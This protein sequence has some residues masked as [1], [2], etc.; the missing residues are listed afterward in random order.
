M[1]LAAGAASGCISLT[2]MIAEPRSEQVL[3]PALTARMLHEAGITRHAVTTPDG[4]RISYLE[5]PAADRG[6]DFAF[7]RSIDGHEVTSSFESHNAHA[8]RALPT[9]GTVLLLHGWS[10]DATS[11]VTWGEALAGHGYRGIAIDLRNF[12]DSARAPAGFGPREAGDV[13]AVL[14]TLQAR[15]E[16]PA[17]VFLFGVSYGA[18]TALF[19]EPALRGRIAGIIA[20]DPFGNAADAIRGMARNERTAPAHGFARLAR[21]WARWRYD[22]DAVEQAIAQADARLQLD[23]AAIDTSPVLAASRTCTVLLHGARDRM[24][25]VAAAR[26][27]AG[28]APRAH[29]TELPDEDHL[30][31]PVRIDWLAAP[32]IDWMDAAGKGECNAL[33]LPPDPARP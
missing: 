32:L 20:M 23:L 25:P 9:R 19:A 16:A 24:I 26:R 14:D 27:L 8:L 18:A 21:S 5:V 1:L 28:M 2:G 12:G 4:V 33:S 29:Y 13:A 3:D 22:D 7:R 30:T 15:G 31:L 11:M 17:P 10:L 6:F